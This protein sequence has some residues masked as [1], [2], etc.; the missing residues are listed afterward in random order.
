VAVAI[1]T[2]SGSVSPD[3]LS[4]DTEFNLLPFF[5]RGAAREEMQHS[6][7]WVRQERE[8]WQ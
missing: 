8:R 7:A 2:L 3:Q 4:D 6:T 5:G 1:E